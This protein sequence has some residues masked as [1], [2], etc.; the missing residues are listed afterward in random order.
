VIAAQL[1]AREDLAEI[2][3]PS[4][5]ALRTDRALEASLADVDRFAA[6]AT[7]W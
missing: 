6:D 7:G 5:L 4:R 3:P 2:P 1:E